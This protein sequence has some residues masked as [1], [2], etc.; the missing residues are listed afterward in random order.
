MMMT[1]YILVAVCAA[2]GRGDTL[3]VGAGD[4][5]N[6]VMLTAVPI[7][8]FAMVLRLFGKTTPRQSV[9]SQGE[10]FK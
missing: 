9:S 1:G 3:R 6:R 5:G 7:I 4:S 10:A 2:W 8:T